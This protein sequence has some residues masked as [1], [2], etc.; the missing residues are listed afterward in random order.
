MELWMF[1]F[2]TF[3]LDCDFFS[4]SNVCAWKY[5]QVTVGQFDIIPGQGKTAALAHEINVN[6]VYS[7]GSAALGQCRTAYNGIAMAGCRIT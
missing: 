2:H 1:R 4:I 7:T 5:I 3:Q 6:I